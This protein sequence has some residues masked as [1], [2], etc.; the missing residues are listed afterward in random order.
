M[1]TAGAYDPAVSSNLV[2]ELWY[3]H[4]PVID[5]ADLVQA[6]RSRQPDAT[7]AS[8]GPAHPFLIAFASLVHHFPDGPAA[9]MLVSVGRP[10]VPDSPAQPSP[11]AAP[12]TAP[13]C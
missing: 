6:V 1:P 11:G 7:T 9:S 5:R 8:T 4:E 12:A 13:A 10:D 2:V 3:D